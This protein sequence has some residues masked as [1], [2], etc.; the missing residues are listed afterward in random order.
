MPRGVYKRSES[1]RERMRKQWSGSG[2]PMYGS[3]RFGDKNP[4]HGKQHSEETK[5]VQRLQKLGIYNGEQNP[6]WRGGVKNDGRGYIMI[7]MPDHPRCDSKGYIYEHRLV[8]ECKLGRPLKRTEIVH[9]KDRNTTNNNEDN[10]EI[11]TQSE[12]VRL[13]RIGCRKHK[14]YG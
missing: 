11:M 13:H 8:M 5:E 7:Y 10:L 1:F 4:F 9:H 2:N 3:Q 12:H 6:N 14:Y